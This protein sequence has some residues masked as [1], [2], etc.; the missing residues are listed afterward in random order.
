MMDHR[1]H[2]VNALDVQGNTG[3]KATTTQ[4]RAT[5]LVAPPR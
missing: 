5:A 4:K 2:W 3:G 1:G